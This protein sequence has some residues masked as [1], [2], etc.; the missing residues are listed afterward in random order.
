[1]RMA[2]E[3]NLKLDFRC[4]VP[5]SDQVQNELRRLI[6]A[7]FLRPGDQLP[8]VRGLGTQLK[9][10]FNTIARAYRTLDQEG[11]ISTQQGRGTYVMEPESGEESPERTKEEWADRLVSN[12]LEKA[13]SQDIPSELLYQSFLQKLEKQPG[14]KPEQKKIQPNRRV[15]R[16]SQKKFIYTQTS[17]RSF[18]KSKTGPGLNKFRK[19]R[20]SK[21]SVH[22]S[23]SRETEP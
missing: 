14:Q 5:I 6:Q 23:L 1:M 17:V 12:L 22:G 2:T 4:K 7:G 3:I 13:N 10:N 19:M 18:I 9:V 16:K 11:L 20:I 21:R 8:T 15:I